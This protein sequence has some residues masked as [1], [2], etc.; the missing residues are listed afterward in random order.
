MKY[1]PSSQII[2]NLKTNGNE[3][4][5][6]FSNLPYK[7]NYWKNSKGEFFTGKTPLD[8]P[9]EKLVPIE[10]NIPPINL[11]PIKPLEESKYSYWTI[12]ETKYNSPLNTP[13]K[14]PSSISPSPTPEDYEF[15]E[16]ERYFLKKRNEVKYKE[17]NQ[18]EW[19]KY[20]DNNPNVPF[21]L[22]LPFRILWEISGDKDKVFNTNKN[23]VERAIQRFKLLGFKS[24]LKERYTQFYK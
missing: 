23:T 10:D 1:Y 24:Y 14:L 13:T 20:V 3:F 16:I 19:K 8:P 15:G 17:I 11:T 2:T 6:E 9:I 7:G 22:F 21:Q 18:E 4:V 12:E 5:N